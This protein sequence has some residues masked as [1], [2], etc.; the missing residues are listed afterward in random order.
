MGRL[1][2]KK[3]RDVFLALLKKK[4][5]EAARIVPATQPLFDSFC[6]LSS[7]TSKDR[8]LSQYVDASTSFRASVKA[9][10]D[11]R[12]SRRDGLDSNICIAG[13]ERLALGSVARPVCPFSLQSEH[14]TRLYYP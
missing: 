3:N 8:S 5:K 14:A 7:W 1:E 9:R 10:S 13:P 11:G 12:R 6:A 2:K 4:K